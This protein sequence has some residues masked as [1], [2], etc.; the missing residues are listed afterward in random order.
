[1][2]DLNAIAVIITPRSDDS[3]RKK[4]DSAGKTF[5]F[6]IEERSYLWEQDIAFPGWA[7]VYRDKTRNFSAFLE[8]LKERTKE[9]GYEVEFMMMYGPEIGGP[10]DPPEGAY[11]CRTIIMSDAGRKASY[12]RS[13][14][15]LRNF[16]NCT[17]W[18][19]IRID[20]DQLQSYG[21][22]KAQR[23]LEHMR[24]MC[25]REVQTLQK[26]GELSVPKARS[27]MLSSWSGY[28]GK[29]FVAATA[30]A[31]VARAI[32]DL[33]RVMCCQNQSQHPNVTL[34]FVKSAYTARRSHEIRKMSSTS[35]R[36]AMQ[37][38]HGLHLKDCL[39]R[40]ALGAQ[41]LLHHKLVWIDEASRRQVTKISL[42]TGENLET[43]PDSASIDGYAGSSTESRVGDDFPLK[44]EEEIEGLPLAPV[45]S[46]LPA[47]DE[48]QLLKG[49]SKPPAGIMY[50]TAS[51]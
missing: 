17:R 32:K 30:K 26:D 46:D 43:D 18:R 6:G 29:D 11:G 49:L 8:R 36:G 38:H 19:R 16:R 13:C 20:K 34:R 39:E 41:I 37:R 21:I 35:V 2:H 5:L 44:M 51:V 1:M 10:D 22:D 40:M 4:C 28:Q 50:D 9:D 23:A 45:E 24:K 12:Q 47:T 27:A 15:R 33:K 7:W 42:P 48:I 25:P 31:T 3:V 14:G